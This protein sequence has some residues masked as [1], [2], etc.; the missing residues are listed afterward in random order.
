MNNKNKFIHRAY[1]KR[2]MK[3]HTRIATGDKLPD[4]WE[5]GQAI[6]RSYIAHHGE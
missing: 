1:H 2:T 6:D 5:G 3:L 4:G